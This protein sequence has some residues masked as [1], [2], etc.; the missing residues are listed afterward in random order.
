VSDKLEEWLL[1][2]I[3][4][5]HE[6]SCDFVTMQVKFREH[7]IHPWTTKGTYFQSPE[8][9]RVLI[10]FSGISILTDLI[11]IEEKELKTVLA[12]TH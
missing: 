12:D 5:M 6:E 1:T 2:L 7:H 3:D 9:C 10:L 4:H 11:Y 8:P